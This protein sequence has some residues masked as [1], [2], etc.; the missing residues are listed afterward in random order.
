[1]FSLV[2]SPQPGVVKITANASGA[3]QGKKGHK[4]LFKASLPGDSSQSRAVAVQS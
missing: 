3:V 1:M 4:P 2:H